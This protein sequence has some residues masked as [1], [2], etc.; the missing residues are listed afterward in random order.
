VRVLFL[1]TSD[2][3]G[4]AARAAY[5]LLKGLQAIDVDAQM[6]VQNKASDDCS[7]LESPG[8]AGRLAAKLYPRLDAAPLRLYPRRR[9]APW[10][11]NMLPGPIGR[12]VVRLAPDVV[13]LH[14]ISNGFVPIGAIAR[15]ERPIVWTLHDMWA[16]TG[17]CHYDQE[18]GRYR[19]MCGACPQLGSA[20]E[21]DM[22]RWIWHAK[23]R[24]WR[25]LR[26][27]V[28]AP[29]RWLAACARASALFR[30]VRVEVIPNG[31]DL[32]VFTAIEKCVARNLL[33]LS[34]EKNLILFGAMS[35]I[36]D[37]RKGFQQLQSALRRLAA[38]SWAENTEVVIL[39]SSRPAEDIDLGIP[40]RYLGQLHDDISLALVYAAAD[41]FV[42]PSTQD[43]LPNTVMEAL[44]CGTPAVAFDIGGM[45]DL[46][47]HE[48]TG[49][50]A[51]PFDIDD[52]AHGIVWTIGDDERRRFLRREARAQAEREFAIDRITA[53]YMAIYQEAISMDAKPC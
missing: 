8:V 30:D 53:M 38:R 35:S 27:I 15:F 33:S 32:A 34:Q 12:Q 47:A 6:L 11:L 25:G 37:P 46:I 41:V 42:A 44:A 14:W 52:L 22:S 29:S 16:F 5:R 48:R 31:L 10:G 36:S 45:P 17:G 39:G 51:R 13:H 4:G 7:V 40:V 23:R 3:A 1:N 43:N 28:V 20:V 50:L 49:Y 18:C 26:L 2:I 9:I 24:A 21:R 19:E